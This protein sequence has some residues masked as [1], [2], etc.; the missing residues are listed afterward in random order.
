MLKVEKHF[1]NQMTNDAPFLIQLMHQPEES[2]LTMAYKT[3]W[4]D[5]S[6]TTRLML[7]MLLVQTANTFKKKMRGRSPGSW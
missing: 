5:F 7:T 2:V 6:Y 3:C 4:C 1:D